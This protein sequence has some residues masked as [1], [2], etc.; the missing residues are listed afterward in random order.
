MFKNIWDDLRERAPRDESAEK[1]AARRSGWSRR[2]VLAGSV[3]TSG[4][5]ASRAYGQV[6]PSLLLDVRDHDVWQVWATG[7]DTGLN[8]Q[9][10]WR[11]P[12]AA[13]GPEVQF[14]ALKPDGSVI[15]GAPPDDLLAKGGAILIQ[16]ATWPG[17]TVRY[18]MRFAFAP[19]PDGWRMSLQARFEGRAI[20]IKDNVAFGPFLNGGHRL[21]RVTAALPRGLFQDLGW[22]YGTEV[23]STVAR[24][25][26]DADLRWWL[27]PTR[28]LIS[29]DRLIAASG[30]V[31]AVHGAG[32]GPL[33]GQLTK[34][35]AR[36]LTSV[37]ALNP[38]PAGRRR[39]LVAAKL[40]DGRDL[41]LRPLSFSRVVTQHWEP[42]G[43]TIR[44][45][46]GDWR[47]EFD[48]GGGFH[49]VDG[50][51]LQGPG[52]IVAALPLAPD[53]HA[54]QTPAG[55]I[56]LRGAGAGA[57]HLLKLRAQ[58]GAVEVFEARG[59]ISH[60]SLPVPG[61][62][63]S[64]LD[65][66]D[67]EARFLLE[68]ARPRTPI[69]GT[70]SYGLSGRWRMPLARARLRIERSA[71]LLSLK[72]RFR[73][74]HLSGGWGQTRIRPNAKA[75]TRPLLVVELPPQHVLERAYLRQYET[76]G[77]L[78]LK[79]NLDQ[80][81]RPSGLPDVLV[82][83]DST[84]GTK[85]LEPFEEVVEARLSGPTRLAFALSADRRGWSRRSS[86]GLALDV[87]SLTDWS[88][89]ELMVARKA[90]AP[91][92]PDGRPDTDVARILRGFDIPAGFDPSAR[93][94]AVLNT[95]LPPDP[96]E[97]AIELPARLILSPDAKGRFEASRA[98][99]RSRKGKVQAAL[100]AARLNI[101]DN[102]EGRELRAVWS[103]DF[104]KA[105][106]YPGGD[107]P[108][109][110]DIVPWNE[111][112]LP[113]G[114][115][116]PF[117]ASL[118]AY[119]RHEL[120]ALTMLWGLPTLPRKPDLSQPDTNTNAAIRRPD[121]VEPPLAWRLT[122][123]LNNDEQ[124]VYLPP[125]VIARELTLT[126][127]GGSMDVTGGFEPPAAPY[128]S[129]GPLFPALSVESWKNRTSLGRDVFVEVM[130]KGFLV[131]T[132]HRAALVKRT[133]R[134]IGISPITKAPVA[135]LIQRKFLQITRPDRTYPR[136]GHPF[137]A[138][139]FPAG[140]V[141][142]RT[143]RTPD[144]APVTKDCEV[145]GLNSGIAFWP[146]T[147]KSPQGAVQFEVALDGRPTTVTL[148]MIFVDNT[149]AHDPVSVKA[150]VDHYNSLHP[151]EGFNVADFHGA[152]HRY[153]PETRIGSATFDTARWVVGV[154][155]RIDRL[156]DIAKAQ[157]QGDG[158]AAYRMDA[159]MEGADQPPWYAYVREAHVH[160]S[161]L[162]H[163]SGR[164]SEHAVVSFDSDYVRFGLE[165]AHNP[166]TLYLGVH[167]YLPS[168]KVD[169]YKPGIEPVRLDLNGKG[170]R[171]GGVGRPDI[172]A[173]ALSQQKGPVGGQSAP[174]R[175]A[176][177][178]AQAA[179]AAP[180]TAAPLTA[181][182]EVIET[183]PAPLT[184]TTT[185][186][187]S[188]GST[189]NTHSRLGGFDPVDFFAPD[190]KLLGMIS[191]RELIKLATQVAAPK[192]KEELSATTEKI[193][194]QIAEVAAFLVNVAQPAL[195]VLREAMATA[196]IALNKPVAAGR[197][198]A[199][200]YPKLA[201][202]FAQVGGRTDALE[203]AIV[204]FT[205]N[206]GGIDGL[207][208]IVDQ[209]QD[210]NQAI[211]ALVAEVD[212][213]AAD[214]APEDLKAFI[215]EVSAAL[216][217]LKKLDPGLLLQPALA[218]VDAVV[219]DICRS[220]ARDLS[221]WI[222]V[223]LGPHV[224]DELAKVCAVAA[225]DPAQGVEALTKLAAGAAEGLAYEAVGRPLLGMVQAA[226]ELRAKTV[227]ML[228]GDLRQM[229]GG[230]VA[231]ALRVIDGAEAMTRGAVL[232]KG[233]GAAAEAC[234]YVRTA[235]FEIVVEP[236]TALFAME[237]EVGDALRRANVA[238]V[239]MARLESDATAKLE[240]ARNVL[241]DARKSGVPVDIA[242]VEASVR[243]AEEATARL[244]QLRLAAAA[245]LER[246]SQQLA[247]LERQRAEVKLRIDNLGA[248]CGAPETLRSLL[249]DTSLWMH[250]R[251]QAI[252]DIQS[253]AR[254]VA[255][256]LQ[257]T[258][259]A[260][261]S[262]A[263]AGL[264]KRAEELA[265]LVRAD[266]Q[267]S[268]EQVGKVLAE[269]G[270]VLRGV[271]SLRASKVRDAL[272]AQ[273]QKLAGRS[274]D[275]LARLRGQTKAFGD[276]AKALEAELETA[277]RELAA[278]TAATPIDQI[279]TRAF[280]LVNA[281]SR[282]AEFSREH[283]R[284]L[285]GMIAITATAL[286]GKV[287][288]SLLAHGLPALKAA[289]QGLSAAHDAV[290]SG[291]GTV[292]T[293]LTGPRAAVLTYLGGD[294]KQL[295]D[296][297]SALREAFK[298]EGLALAEARAA[299]AQADPNLAKA[300][301]NLAPFRAY[302]DD[303]ANP[304]PALLDVVDRIASLF[305][306]LLHGRLQD[307]VDVSALRTALIESLLRPPL[308]SLT[309]GFDFKTAV[310]S[311]EP[312]FKMAEDKDRKPLGG[313]PGAPDLV[314]TFE[315]V[316]D[317]KDPGAQKVSSKGVLQ[318]FT[319]KIFDV[320]RLHFRAA[321]FEGRNGTPPT[322]DVKI[323]QVELLE[324]VA[325]IKDL[326][327][328]LSPGKGGGF[329]LKPSLA[330]AGVEAGYTLD[331]G[332]ISI[333][334]IS[335][336]NVSFT[337]SIE[338][339]FDNR[340]ALIRTSMGLR[341]RPVGISAAPY[342]GFAFLSLTATAKGLVG[343]EASFEYG[344]AVAFSFGPLSGQ[345]RVTLGIYVAQLPEGATISGYFVAAGSA[346]IACF[347]VSACL[348][349]SVT[350]SGGHMAGEATFT[351]SFSLGLTDVSFDVGVSHQIEQGW[352]AG[353][354]GSRETPAPEK[355]AAL[356]RAG[357]V[358]LIAGPAR[359]ARPWQPHQEPARVRSKAV[360][361][362]QDWK[363]YRSYFDEAL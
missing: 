340:A 286:E 233:L 319:V 356:R 134:R 188:Y 108:S 211:G 261:A 260:P 172:I 38:R 12:R 190:A 325:F 109:R 78:G 132:G 301:A 264:P 345:G 5:A 343:F 28:A 23:L 54:V 194:Q 315:M 274:N 87:D 310:K 45:L 10:V 107:Q 168:E 358:A 203:R 39:H 57:G 290:D 339:P 271:S 209:A 85:L 154:R 30:L 327:A 20:V 338:I 225:N 112:P 335:F 305:D 97:T 73:E 169:R 98:P 42:K 295:T 250:L 220:F 228:K 317:L 246:I 40:K 55:A 281:V 22:D 262:C 277:V 63:F 43:P 337:A 36:P 127:L 199:D 185:T 68:W 257:P 121:N 353:S 300:A 269:L 316:V 72:F 81:N 348:Q 104:R 84:S 215:V 155:G 273:V 19:G 105:A 198:A 16:N 76:D 151:D 143:T 152:A 37:T 160:L 1:A 144:L 163:F 115:P 18:A 141:R 244:T 59:L 328:W 326:Q 47:V 66:D 49:G 31:V 176:F 294:A 224:D 65:F 48:N 118:S 275:E 99:A 234:A 278:V 258:T 129:K 238:L 280:R 361:M 133:E 219:G 165:P 239:A 174:T 9:G 285:V 69:L 90:G 149:A 34:A 284:R 291:L 62:D 102:A 177:P 74:L 33:N 350:Q 29:E 83:P 35:P 330:P 331:L 354:G 184:T 212:R 167:G 272:S 161:A 75:D 53:P 195:K 332:T 237:A 17:T 123:L 191:F 131:P 292:T 204:A 130:Y 252:L 111:P 197:T 201:Q 249:E 51:V 175:D 298:N 232:A 282:T 323:A 202:T 266:L 114:K 196:S 217:A 183:G 279:K 106:F 64:R 235:I 32:A 116:R 287:Q 329:F 346:N 128:L 159:T 180:L 117:R 147:T 214:P 61:A 253:A 245:G 293:E 67:E 359:A 297:T 148:P 142:L 70:F 216:E 101:A 355:A 349:I 227:E 344:G 263:G 71:D 222:Q 288:A 110:K 156:G 311:V 92:G 231:A 126:A 120:V 336:I 205:E 52:A 8:W 254:R 313:E 226:F 207:M 89:L 314:M 91:L 189:A 25:G 103:P 333:G 2:D 304:K 14:D 138:R 15:S 267:A 242:Q 146:S 77:P 357:G 166:G 321:T 243:S 302:I 334:T 153:A 268:F 21:S 341:E 113:D 256:G 307:V 44:G 308:T 24:I 41:R 7:P 3:A 94:D 50:L 309:I 303:P 276:A 150:V 124:G 210:L 218:A 255:E 13:F 241:K 251:L 283:E 158:D 259:P 11:L 79:P 162:Q 140:S 322:V 240:Q 360:C 289:V 80:N 206:S 236:T 247:V 213:L 351:F 88:K 230:V 347:G 145:P 4:L 56:G 125:A 137:D 6:E 100:W 157:G 221:T 296:P 135:Y 299:L 181:L 223:A 265:T 139:D 193:G 312:F 164:A 26:W 270:P 170:D 200:L 324:A 208:K 96:F 178:A 318:P 248:A 352:G 342:G 93:L 363:T 58:D 119:D 182:V 187:V 229:A 27:E 179:M 192:L 46:T 122:G 171:S 95:V 136:L 186:P 86:Q 173:V 306:S 320:V 60:L 82:E 362:G